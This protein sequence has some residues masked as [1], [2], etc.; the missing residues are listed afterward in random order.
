MPWSRAFED[1]ITLPDGMVLRTLQDAADYMMKLS[2]EEQKADHWLLAGEMVIAAAGGRGI[3]MLARIGMLSAI[4]HGR[5]VEPDALRRKREKHLRLSNHDRH[6]GHG[7]ARSRRSYEGPSDRMKFVTDRS[8]ADRKPP[9]ASCWK[10]CGR[11]KSPSAITPIRAR[12]TARASRP[13]AA[14]T[15]TPRVGNM[16]SRKAGSISTGPAPGSSCCRPAR[17]I[18]SI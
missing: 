17:M 18:R 4:N 6:S 15:N 9:R 5:P 11:R 14:S 2:E 16:R 10:S 3:L 13:A 1:P 12:P 7:G 8:F